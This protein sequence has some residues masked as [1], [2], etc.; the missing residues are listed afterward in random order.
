MSKKYLHSVA[1]QITGAEA[2]DS[3]IQLLAYKIH[4]EKGGADLDHWLEAER[5]LKK[6]LD[7][8]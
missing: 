7:G 6:E 3:F 1:K 2:D 5:I 4:Q 8:G